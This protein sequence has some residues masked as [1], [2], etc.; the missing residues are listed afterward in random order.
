MTPTASAPATASSTASVASATPASGADPAAFCGS[1]GGAGVTIAGARIGL[2]EPLAVST[3]T[4]RLPDNTPL[5]PQVLDQVRFSG[6]VEKGNWVLFGLDATVPA[7]QH[8]T[9][10]GITARIVAFQLLV[11]AIPNIYIGCVDQFYRDPGG[12]TPTTACPGLPLPPAAGKVAFTSVAPGATASGIITDPHQQAPTSAALP[13]PV[14][15]PF[16]QYALMIGVTVPQP[17]TYTFSFGLWQDRSGPQYSGPSISAESIFTAA[18]HEWGGQPC[19]AAAMR[20]QLPP[21]S[22]PPAE[23]ICPGPVQPA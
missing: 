13:Y 22:N 5:K 7:G 19:T 1:A 16:G 15:A 18:L 23:V 14:Q 4:E 3:H 20:S 12:W 6:E 17:G 21:P 11:E 10:C 8:A 9:V 2:D